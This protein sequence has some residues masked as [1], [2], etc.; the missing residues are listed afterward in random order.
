[1][2][3]TYKCGENT[4]RQLW[5]VSCNYKITT[6]LYTYLR[7]EYN[8]SASKVWM[9]ST[10]CSRSIGWSLL[11]PG[12]HVGPCNYLLVSEDK[13]SSTEGRSQH[14]H[15]TSAQDRQKSAVQATQLTT[16]Q[17]RAWSSP[18]PIP[19]SGTQLHRHLPPPPTTCA[20]NLHTY[21]HTYV[22]RNTNHK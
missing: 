7:M 5:N 14:S 8:A 2:T 6:N 3:Y 19:Q 11:Y 1:M 22:R 21:I 15:D 4:T 13:P 20:A 12:A 18:H 10:I 9:M 16:S 17:C